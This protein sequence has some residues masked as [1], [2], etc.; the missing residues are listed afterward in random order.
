MAEVGYAT[1]GIIPSFQGFE[2]N[3][4]RGIAGPMAMA[5]R[6]GG[7]QF[8]NEAGNNAGKTF[9]GRFRGFLSRAGLFTGLGAGLGLAAFAKDAVQLEAQYGKTMAQIRVATGSAAGQLERLDALAIEL[10]KDTVFSANEASEAMLELAKNG[11]APTTIEAGALKS[12]L[13]LAAAGG[14]DLKMAAETMGNSLNAF[15]LQAKQTPQVAAALAGAANASSASVQSIAE[16]LQQVSAVAADA[17]QTVQGTTAALAA[18]ANAGIAGSDAGTSLKTTFARLI[19]ATNTARKAFLQYGLTAFETKGSID[20]LAKLGIKP[21][22]NKFAD[23]YRAI[24]Q[25]V[26]STGLAVK[27]SEEMHKQTEDLLY[28]TGLMQNAFVKQN[29]EF[30]SVTQIAGVLNDRFADLSSSER[31]AALE[32]LFGSDARRGATILMREGADGIREYIKATSDQQAADR[33]AKANMEGTAGALERLAGSWETAKLQFGKALAPAALS[34]L[35]ALSAGVDTMGP[36]LADATTWFIEKGVP[37]LKEFAGHARTAAGFAGDLVGYLN[38]LPKVVKIGGLAA[39]ATAIGGAKLRGG[40]NGAL[41]TAGKALGM[42]KPIPVFVTNPGFGIGDGVGGPKGGK[43]A[44]LGKSLGL[45]AGPIIAAAIGSK[46]AIDSQGGRKGEP[47]LPGVPS[48]GIGTLGAADKFTLFDGVEEETKK[49]IADVHRFDREATQLG[50]YRVGLEMPTLNPLFSRVQ[51]Y[52]SLLDGLDGRV[53]TTF[54]RSVQQNNTVEDTGGRGGKTPAP[55]S[56]SGRQVTYQFNG[57]QDLSQIRRE[58]EHEERRSAM[59]GAD[60]RP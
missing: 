17:D 53:V 24:S 18:M 9:A 13:T 4:T 10:G 40:G 44:A 2:R 30:K 7:A 52:G 58:V 31:A 60:F 20:E 35:D 11:I 41:G 37:A 25:Y 55:T 23:V 27:G 6:T 26:V 51:Q 48:S 50:P 3:L 22:T 33:M 12:A 14:V 43:A 36:K 54:I 34:V 1:L 45:A 46:A 38:D 32:T 16:G 57:I 59:G 21:L 42:A 19:P 28:S 56:G 8:G 39:L 29:G 47:F 15:R 5:G 49:A